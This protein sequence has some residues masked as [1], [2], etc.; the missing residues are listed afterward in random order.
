[1]NPENPDLMNAMGA[2]APDGMPEP[3]GD[4]KEQCVPLEALQ[5]PDETEQM[6]APEVGD[7]VDYQVQGK[8]TR[9]EGGM[10]YVQ[11]TS[12]NGQELDD[13]DQDESENAEPAPEAQDAAD[14]SALEDE[15]K[16]TQL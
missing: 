13:K 7:V 15:A 2:D 9:V 16:N 1:M 12:I 14:Y 10:A 6:T 5:M 11:P 4:D 8:V 3:D